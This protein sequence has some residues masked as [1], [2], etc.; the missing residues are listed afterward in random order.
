[1]EFTIELKQGDY[2]WKLIISGEGQCPL[3]THIDEWFN[4]LNILTELIARALVVAEE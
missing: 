4:A 2:G 3:T 1:M